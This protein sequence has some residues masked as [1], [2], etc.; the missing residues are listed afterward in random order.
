MG[1]KRKN[2]V[3]RKDIHGVYDNI[4]KITKDVTNISHKLNVLV[5]V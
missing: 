4:D 5:N 3:S 2:D 1:E